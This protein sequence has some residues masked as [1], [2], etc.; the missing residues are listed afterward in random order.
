MFRTCV[1]TLESKG[2]KTSHSLRAT[3]CKIGLEKGGPKK[4]LMQRTGHRSVKSL[5]TYQTVNNMQKEV[6]SDIFMARNIGHARADY[7]ANETKNES[8]STLTIGTLL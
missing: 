5:H 7:T 3:T 2:Y 6:V 8:H 1:K 4:L